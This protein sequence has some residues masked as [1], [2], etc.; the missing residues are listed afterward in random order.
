VAFFA[1]NAGTER[2]FP[3]LIYTIL[4]T[5]A[6]SATYALRPSERLPTIALVGNATLLAASLNTPTCYYMRLPGKLEAGY[7]GHN[8]FV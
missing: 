5:I 1:L 3:F 4:A 8:N 2:R 7:L 6:R